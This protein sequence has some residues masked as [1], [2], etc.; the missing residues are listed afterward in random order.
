MERHEAIKET[1]ENT[2]TQLTEKPLFVQLRNERVSV[3]QEEVREIWTPPPAPRLDPQPY[4]LPV[5]CEK[6]LELILNNPANVIA[7]L[8]MC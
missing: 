3:D 6:D 1:A 8:K 5:I 2:P 7:I 4:P